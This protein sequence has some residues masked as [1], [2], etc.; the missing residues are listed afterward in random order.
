MTRVL[1]LLTFSCLSRLMLRTIWLISAFLAWVLSWIGNQILFFW[2]VGN[3]IWMAF[4]HSLA[5]ADVASYASWTDGSSHFAIVI[6]IKFSWCCLAVILKYSGAFVLLLDFCVDKGT[7]VLLLVYGRSSFVDPFSFSSVSSDTSNMSDSSS[8]SATLFLYSLYWCGGFLVSTTLSV[9]LLSDIDS[10]LELLWDLFKF[11]NL[12][13][14][15]LTCTKFRMYL[16]LIH[17]IV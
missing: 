4:F 14:S 9:S 8:L 15:N 17:C 3:S 16:S 2:S 1:N 12:S 5:L 13:S 7:S 10:P 11:G 6:L